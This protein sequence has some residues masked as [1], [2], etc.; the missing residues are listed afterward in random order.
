MLSCSI[1]ISHIYQNLSHLLT[2]YSNQ[3][4]GPLL[5]S[6][7]NKMLET[8]TMSWDSIPSFGSQRRVFLIRVQAGGGGSLAPRNALLFTQ[9]QARLPGNSPKKTFQRKT[10]L[11]RLFQNKIL[12]LFWPPGCSPK[13]SILIE[14][15]IIFTIH[16]GVPLFLETPTN[17]CYDFLQ[18]IP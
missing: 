13:S 17:R 16:F 7:R 8:H 12:W 9:I 2:P 11:H 3:S 5:K 6:S 18:E 10:W 14:F 1:I 4:F 15:S